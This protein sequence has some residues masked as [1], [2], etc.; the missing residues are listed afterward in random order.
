MGCSGGYHEP[1]RL[2]QQELIATV[3]ALFPCTH[4]LRCNKVFFD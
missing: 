2:I 4:C 1:E 3:M